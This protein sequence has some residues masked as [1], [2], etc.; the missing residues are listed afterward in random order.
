MEVKGKITKVL[1]VQSGTSKN[2]KEWSKIS[3]L[4]DTEEKYNNLY[5]FDIFGAEKVDKSKKLLKLEVDLG[6]EKR[7]ILSG[8][9]S[10]MARKWSSPRSRRPARGGDSVPGSR[11]SFQ[12]ASSS[13]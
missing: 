5:C 6:F 9:S 10:R 12:R 7:T 8:Q 1:E 3:F 4:L 13:Y 2:G 11:G